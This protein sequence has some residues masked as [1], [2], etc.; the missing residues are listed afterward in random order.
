MQDLVFQTMVTGS[1]FGVVDVIFN[2]V[3]SYSASAQWQSELLSIERN[4]YIDIMDQYPEIADEVLIFAKF[5][6]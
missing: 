3:R 2:A 5:R 4:K 6:K 1:Y